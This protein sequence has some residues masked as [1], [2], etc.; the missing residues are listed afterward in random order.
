MADWFLVIMK[1]KCST[2]LSL[3]S[4]FKMNWQL[5]THT[6]GVPGSL[7]VHSSLN[8][9]WVVWNTYID[10]QRFSNVAVLSQ[11]GDHLLPGT[12]TKI[13]EVVIDYLFINYKAAEER[14]VQRC[15]FVWMIIQTFR[16]SWTRRLHKDPLAAGS[17]SKG[18]W[19][20][21]SLCGPLWWGSN[22]GGHPG[23]LMLKTRVVTYEYTT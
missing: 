3:A 14:Y 23:L 13:V 12:L 4:I 17:C 19:R 22:W 10:D 21:W 16:K 18:C 11:V 9:G 5:F 8:T 1:S 2:S 7:A 6:Q 15:P 20:C